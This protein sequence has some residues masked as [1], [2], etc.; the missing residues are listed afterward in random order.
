VPRRSSK[1]ERP[2]GRPAGAGRTSARQARKGRTS[3]RRA[4][5]GRTSAYEAG[6]RLLA[7]RAHSTAELRRK[8][9]R[10]GYEGDDV[11]GAVARLSRL[12]YLDDAAFAEGHVRRRSSARGPLALSAELAARGVE[13]RDADA[14]LARLDPASQLAAATR[15]ARR[16]AG[17]RRP[18]GYQELLGTVGSKLLRRGFSLG[19]A[20]EACRTLWE[21]TAG[22]A[23]A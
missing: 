16:L 23:E 4:R 1:A 2:A 15:L 11:D 12:G 8:L 20:R 18:A 22:Q 6:V 10:R 9:A 5:A 13:R 7:R 19:V 17:N 3:A 14:A 21:G